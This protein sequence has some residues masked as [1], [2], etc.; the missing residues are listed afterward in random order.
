VPPG[1]LVVLSSSSKYKSFWRVTFIG[2]GF[3]PFN[4]CLREPQATAL[5][6]IFVVIVFFFCLRVPI[7]NTE[8]PSQAIIIRWLRHSKPSDYFGFFAAIKCFFN[9]CLRGPQAT[10]LWRFFLCCLLDLS[11][12]RWLRHSKPPVVNTNSR[13][14]LDL[15]SSPVLPGP[16]SNHCRV[17]RRSA[18][19][20]A[21]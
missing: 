8:G 20:R 2:R 13:T 9:R 21:W 3:I 6:R 10:G 1:W 5:K 18:N 4:R 12:T 17:W 11:I 14:L 7:G 16:P 19:R 15:P